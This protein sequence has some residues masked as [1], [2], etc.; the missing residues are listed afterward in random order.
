MTIELS[1]YSTKGKRV[2]TVPAHIVE[3]NWNPCFDRVIEPIDLPAGMVG[4]MFDGNYMEVD[5]EMLKVMDRTE[6]PEVYDMLSR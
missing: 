5:G 3:R 6:T 1:I 2:E 4:T